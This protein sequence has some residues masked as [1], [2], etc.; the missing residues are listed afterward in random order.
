MPIAPLAS[1]P[2]SPCL[3]TLSEFAVVW[4]VGVLT[5]PLCSLCALTLSHLG[6]AESGHNV[7]ERGL[8]AVEPGGSP[9]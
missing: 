7:H 5:S 9:L 4:L 2:G 8:G 3:A 6:N 1:S